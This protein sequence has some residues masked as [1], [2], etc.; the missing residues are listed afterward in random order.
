MSWVISHAISAVK[1][2]TPHSLTEDFGY[3]ARGHWRGQLAE[4][5]ACPLGESPRF[6][7]GAEPKIDETAEET[8]ELEGA[9]HYFH[10]PA[11]V[12]SSWLIWGR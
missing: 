7:R 6:P 5:D 10:G 9:A 12:M 3:S 8:R 11:Q 2:E 1:S 4:P